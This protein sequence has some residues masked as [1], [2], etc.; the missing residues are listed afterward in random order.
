[1]L[2]K[3][4]FG[5]QAH[6]TIYNIQSFGPIP[7]RRFCKTNPILIYHVSNH[8]PFMRNEP[9]SRTP[10][11]P[12]PRIYAKRTQFRPRPRPS[13]HQKC[14][15]NPICSD[16]LYETNPISRT[17]TRPMSKMR[18]TNTIYDLFL[19]NEPNLPPHAALSTFAFPLSPLSRATARAPQ[20]QQTRKKP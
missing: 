16:Q 7:A 8:P 3:N 10:S 4:G 9:N 12:P 19:R 11:L 2:S 6:S 14:E 18:K 1:M 5:Q 13:S 20:S 17:T 15:T